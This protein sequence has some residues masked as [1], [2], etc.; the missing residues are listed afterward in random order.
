MTHQP[1][2]QED[3]SCTSS[4]PTVVVVGGGGGGGGAGSANE[5]DTNGCS[6]DETTAT[7]IIAVPQQY[8]H[9]LT[10]TEIELE[11]FS[12]SVKY[13]W[14]PIGGG[15]GGGGGCNRN[16]N[17]NNDWKRSSSSSTKT[18]RSRNGIP[19]LPE[20]P[21]SLRFS[22]DFVGPNRPCII[23]NA[24]LTTTPTTTTITT[25]S[26]RRGSSRE[27]DCHNG[28]N[29]DDDNDKDNTDNNHSADDQQQQ[30]LPLHIDL[31]QI[32]TMVPIHDTIITVDVTPD[33]YGDCI[34][35][36]TPAS[37]ATTQQQQQ[38][39]F[40]RPKECRI[41]LYE[42]R[43]RLRNQHQPHQQ[44]Q[45]DHE[46]N[47]D[48]CRYQCSSTTT[49]YN[50]GY[51][52]DVIDVDINQRPYVVFRSTINTTIAQ[53]DTTENIA[54]N[55]IMMNRQHVKQQEGPQCEDHSHAENERNSL[56]TN[57]NNN[58]IPDESVVYYSH[59][60]DCLRDDTEGI[61]LLQS[62]FPSTITW[63]QEAFFFG[64]EDADDNSKY[65]SNN[66]HNGSH[67]SGTEDENGQKHNHH[68]DAINIWIGNERSVSSMHKDHYENLIY[69]TS[70]EKIFTLCPP[71]DV[72]YLYEHVQYNDSVFE[73][74]TSTSSS[75]YSSA[76]TTTRRSDYNKNNGPNKSDLTWVVQPIQEE[77][78]S[79]TSVIRE[80]PQEVDEEGGD[81]RIIAGHTDGAPTTS[82]S[83]T[84][85]WIAPDI[86]ILLH[87]STE[88]KIQ[89][90]Q[91]YPLLKYAHPIEVTVKAG[92]ML[93]L[94]KLWYH[95]VTQSCETVAINYWYEMS[96][97]SSPLWCYYEF[98]QQ[99]Q[100]TDQKY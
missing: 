42:F 45:Y 14:C 90:L 15:G 85:R 78:I 62:L 58:S 74:S 70:G 71:S 26:N 30:L 43:Q 41:S 66:N 1:P 80:Q 34:R 36:T 72:I 94:P 75:S 84:V 63:A 28:N 79:S 68:I 10:A 22:R 40:V 98:L 39:L 13:L 92:E 52:D 6:A 27:T 32:C 81:D 18:S 3:E 17:N 99:L 86:S 24:I 76:S 37:T 61:S 89:L 57:N 88:Q 8:H 48:D 51:H 33:G 11:S 4:S 82:S 5:G 77:T 31:D 91:H 44:Q 21:T 53:L 100:H 35:T 49:H 69:V 20:P 50:N 38:Q 54:D 59:Q 23:Q 9:Q 12:E 16:S 29:H 19:I 55:D 67:E 73:T 96:F 87:G 64:D 95:R 46:Q 47:N 65:N 60:N 7:T 93:Y 2:R 56:N 25:N 83:S 97:Q